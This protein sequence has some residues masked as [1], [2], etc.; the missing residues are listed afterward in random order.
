MLL[1][2]ENFINKRYLD[3]TK[4]I[5]LKYF[6]QNLFLKKEDW[7][8]EAAG[9]GAYKLTYESSRY[10]I[11]FEYEKLCFTIQIRCEGASSNFF[12]QNKDIPNNL[13]EKNIEAA[14]S[15]LKNNINDGNLEFFQI[16]KKGKIKKVERIFIDDEK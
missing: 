9:M 10:Q 2:D 7:S 5:F 1:G 8:N 13:E 4:K 6:G 11:I 3:Y 14:I 12:G 15:T 16:S